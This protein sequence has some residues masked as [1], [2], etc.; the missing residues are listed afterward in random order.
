MQT[1]L[2][3]ADQL[4]RGIEDVI[5]A[6]VK[7]GVVCVHSFFALLTVLD[8]E[9]VI[10]PLCHTEKELSPDAVMLIVHTKCKEIMAKYPIT[11]CLLSLLEPYI[12]RLAS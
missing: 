7:E 4:N 11:V 8:M 5:T 10:R 12:S 9:L 3:T 6:A 1:V 2:Q